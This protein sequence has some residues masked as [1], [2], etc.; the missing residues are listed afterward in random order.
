M[1]FLLRIAASNHITRT[2]RGVFLAIMQ[3]VAISLFSAR[4]SDMKAAVGVGFCG[5]N[6]AAVTGQMASLE[7][8]Y[9]EQRCLSG[10]LSL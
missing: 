7:L 2:D 9:C 5:N 6:S 1:A 4:C 3:K 8:F 10:A